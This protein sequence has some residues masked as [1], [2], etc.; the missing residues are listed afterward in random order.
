MR[1]LHVI[2]RLTA[3]GPTRSLIDLAKVQ[4]QSGL[5]YVHKVI[6]LQRNAYPMALIL[7]KRAGVDVV[8]QPDAELLQRE[9]AAA[10]IV[11]VSFWNNPDFYT[12]LRSQW[13]EMRL[14][15]W[16]K[17]AGDK[18]PQV[19]IPALVA[20]ADYCVATCPFTLQLPVMQLALEAGR[21][22]MACGLTDVDRLAGFRPLP[23]ETFN[24]GYIGTVNYSKMHPQFISMSAKVN[25]PNIRFVVCGGGSKD[26]LKQQAV[27][28][29]AEEK[30]IFRGFV[31]NIKPVLETLD[32][33]GYPLCEDTYATSD[34]SLQEAMYA[35]IPPVV[36][37]YGGVRDLVED[38][39][40]GL[41]VHNEAEYRGALEYLYHNPADRIRLGQNAQVYAKQF[42]AG[43]LVSQQFDTIYA[44]MMRQPKRKRSWP[45]IEADAPPANRF[46]E[47]LGETA[48]QFLFSRME[49]NSQAEQKVAESSPLLAAGEGGI[50]HYRNSYPNDPYLRFWSGLVLLKQKRFNLARSEFQEAVQL[51]LE[52]SRIEVYMAQ[53][54]AESKP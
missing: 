33:F 28:L 1:I 24:V 41:V 35:G 4:A 13:P 47:A 30:F 45:G 43:D 37:P 11:Q 34:R 9:I 39:R 23:H 49:G 14:L 3:G 29:H 2:D 36:F 16:A 25:V 20:Y 54:H 31:E 42:F 53:I 48:P 51:G 17:I 22:G 18:P 27:N 15:V 12:F 38:G 40:T 8:R 7:A 26:Q 6:V 10:D 19:I 44:Q 32:I 46:I 52:P 5:S 21:A 50:V